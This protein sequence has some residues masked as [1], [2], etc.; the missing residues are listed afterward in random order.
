MG[1]KLTKLIEAVW[2]ERGFTEMENGE[3]FACLFN[4]GV[5]V[6]SFIDHEL[7]VFVI[8]GEPYKI[9]FTLCP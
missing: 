4:D 5:V 9:D 6:V 8:L 7:K 2:E 3:E 1:N